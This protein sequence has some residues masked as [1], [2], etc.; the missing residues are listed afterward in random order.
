MRPVEHFH[1]L[2]L[3]PPMPAGASDSFRAPALPYPRPTG[4]VPWV[5]AFLD[6]LFPPLCP[7]CSRRLD[8]GRRDPL[9]GGCWDGLERLAPPFCVICGLPFGSFGA[10]DQESHRCEA[11]RRQAPPFIY[12]RAVTLYGDSVRSAIHALKFRGKHSLSRPLGDL[13]ALEGARLIPGERVD[14]LIPVPLHP[15]REAQRGFNQALLLARQVGRRWRVP[16]AEGALR[17]IVSTRSQTELSGAERR[18]NVTGAF[19]LRR[20]HAVT[21]RHVLLIDDIFTTGATASECARVLLAGGAA[22]VGVLTV[23]RVP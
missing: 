4:W 19:S 16:V 17:R 22:S 11:C 14:C 20:P 23:A 7:L 21:G 18:R 12:A 10:G 6:L 9:C 1:A 13:L 8:E 15:R 3:I 5:T 2:A